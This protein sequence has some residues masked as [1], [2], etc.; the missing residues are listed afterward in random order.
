MKVKVPH[1]LQKEFIF[2][3][4][5]TLYLVFWLLST[6]F[7]YEY[8]E[9]V[10]FRIIKL[11]CITMLVLNEIL[12]NKNS[13]RS[14]H[15]LALC[16]FIYI[17]VI[18]NIGALSDVAMLLIFIYCGRNVSFLK[19][20][21]FTFTI[22]SVALIFT[23]GSAYLGIIPNY[24]E[25]TDGRYRE[26][27][28]FTYALYPAAILFDITA[29]TIYIRKQ[30]IKMLELLI[31]F[32]INWIIF[33][34]TN[35]RLSFYMSLLMIAGAAF[36]KFFPSVLEKSRILH[37]GMISS[38]II[39]FLSSYYLIYNYNPDIVWLER[40]NKIFNNRL[41]LAHK[42]LELYG[43]SLIGK[44]NMEWI[45][46]GLNSSGKKL[47]G[48]YLWVDNLYISNLQ[49]F[50]I[51]VAV[52]IIVLLTITLIKAFKI[53]DYY[54]MY[55]LTFIAGRYMIDDLFLYLHYN[56]FWLATGTLLI[57]LKKY[58]RPQIEK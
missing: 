19:V 33:K 31:L 41:E 32:L 52:I 27:I 40:L 38:Y 3:I 26:Y 30:K 21:K 2:L 39:A 8:Y 42:S 22:N 14:V 34:K 24:V 49:K 7:Y 5:Y 12:Y 25:I 46:N 58:S 43:T 6:T 54:L 9:G 23:V 44:N 10:L 17:I 28:G 48:S 20:A 18:R 16:A 36:W 1:V 29:L 55:I 35:A 53:K 37:W 13:F 4:S 57:G 11:V 51:L 15:G 56:T 47:T 45:G 50:G